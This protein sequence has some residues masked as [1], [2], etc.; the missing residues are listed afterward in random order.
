M[1]L[2]ICQ[3]VINVQMSMSSRCQFSEN[4]WMTAEMYEFVKIWHVY[5]YVLENAIV[6]NQSI[7]KSAN[8]P[9]IF[10]M[11]YHFNFLLSIFSICCGASGYPCHVYNILMSPPRGAG[12]DQMAHFTRMSPCMVNS[13]GHTNFAVWRK[14]NFGFNSM[15]KI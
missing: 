7:I 6:Y 11:K 4:F 1:K 8:I 12:Q 5:T 10:I 9:S 3:Y 13:V 14:S 15:K 2:G